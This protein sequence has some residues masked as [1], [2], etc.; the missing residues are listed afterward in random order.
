MHDEI[1]GF[2]THLKR[3]TGITPSGGSIKDHDDD[4]GLK[5]VDNDRPSVI[6]LKGTEPKSQVHMSFRGRNCHTPSLPPKTNT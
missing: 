2:I 5:R 6:S 4:S 3:G 1:I